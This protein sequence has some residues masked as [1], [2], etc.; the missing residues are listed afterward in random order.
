MTT[1]YD[2]PLAELLPA[3]ELRA[4]ARPGWAWRLL[5]GGTTVALRRSTNGERR[6][7]VGRK[8][9]PVTLYA[10]ARW[11]AEVVDLCR[12]LGVVGWRRL[13]DVREGE[14]VAAVFVAPPETNG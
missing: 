1:V 9:A 11:E 6:L 12:A 3:L 13:D 10:R 4:V 14:G 7:R 2:G 8:E 5:P